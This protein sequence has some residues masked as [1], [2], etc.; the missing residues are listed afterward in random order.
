MYLLDTVMNVP[1][2]CQNTYSQQSVHSTVHAG[3]AARATS[4]C[5]KVSRRA[6]DPAMAIDWIKAY[7]PIRSVMLR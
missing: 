4:C 7:E 2:T 6:D 3:V 5:N 1:F